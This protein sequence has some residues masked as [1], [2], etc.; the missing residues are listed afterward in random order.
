[1]PSP[2]VKYDVIID[3]VRPNILKPDDKSGSSSQ[4][5]RLGFHDYYPFLA[6]LDSKSSK[7]RYVTLNPPIL[8]IIDE[9]GLLAGA[10]TSIMSSIYSNLHYLLSDHHCSPVRWAFFKPSGRRLEFLADWL[11]QGRIHVPMEKVYPFD[12]VPQALLKLASGG[13]NGKIVVEVNKNV[14]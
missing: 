7:S 6:N 13:N 1:M 5:P 12:Q 9:S 3:C 11:V 2:N 8:K 10:C 4:L 14:H